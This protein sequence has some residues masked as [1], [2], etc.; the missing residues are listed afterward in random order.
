M[1]FT[2][3]VLLVEAAVVLRGL[4]AGI[5]RA[6]R[7]LTPLLFAA[8][9]VMIGRALTLPGAG[10][11]V[12]W[13]FAFHP[14]NVTRLGDD[15]R[16]GPG[17]LLA[18]PGRHVHGHVRLVPGRTGA[19]LRT[20]AALTVAGDTLAGLLAG[21][22]IFPAVFALGMEPDSGPGLL[23]ATMPELFARLPAGWVFG[24]LFFGALGGVA[25]LSG[26]A[27]YEVLV[28][29]LADALGWTRRRGVLVV[30]G[31]A[32]LLALP[33]MINLRVFV[34][35]D[36]TFG[37]GGQ[38]FGAVLAVVTVGWVMRRA[39][40]LRQI[41]GEHPSALDRFLAAWLRW[42]IPTAVAG[43]AAWWLLT[44]VLGAAAACS[45]PARRRS[46][47][48]LRAADPSTRSSAMLHRTAF[49]QP[50]WAASSP[51]PPG[52]ALAQSPAGA[53]EPVVVYLVR[54]V[55]RAED[56]TNDPPISAEG[57]ARA[58]ALA[59]MLA[60][61][62]ITHVHSTDYERTRQTAAP[63]ADALGLPVETYDPRDLPALAAH[64]R[65]TPGRHLVVGHSNTTPDAVAALGGEPATAIGEMEYDRLYVVVIPADAAARPTTVLLRF[66]AAAHP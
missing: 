32:L 60:D 42:V 3:F 47:F 51:R 5:E 4:R 46:T 20:D 1:A 37:S 44:D 19:R 62:G 40:L 18:R 26:I 9:L 64:L 53:G 56:G 12:R 55:E 38:T 14:E 23:F 35:W 15:G 61:A 52:P 45:G 65:G 27:A 31:L 21:L 13:L 16:A 6:S 57:R 33:P 11:G 49:S 2:S 43:A 39:D 50:P 30:G 25:L 34:P 36:L 17:G 59:G 8:L 28:V 7:V 41:A 63:L 66:G 58:D 29:G 22:A 24:T 10:A 48:R 54:H